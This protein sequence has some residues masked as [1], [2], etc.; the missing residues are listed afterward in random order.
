MNKMI[1]NFNG[2]IHI[3]GT[4]VSHPEE[5][6]EIRELIYNVM[7]MLDESSL[8]ALYEETEDDYDDS[9]D[10]FGFDA[11]TVHQEVPASREAHPAEKVGRSNASADEEDIPLLFSFFIVDPAVCP[12]EEAAFLIKEKIDEYLKAEAAQ[13]QRPEQDHV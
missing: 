13:P 7:D 2:P 11:P 6:R 3:C 8:D 5:L 4:G 1:I 9:E 12:P 10:E